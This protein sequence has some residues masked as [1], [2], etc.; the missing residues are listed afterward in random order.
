MGCTNLRQA[1]KFELYLNNDVWCLSSWLQALS[2]VTTHHSLLFNKKMQAFGVW[3]N[4][5]KQ[6]R[7]QLVGHS[8]SV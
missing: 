2:W 1:N 7:H 5:I 4:E 8:I 6:E 3:R